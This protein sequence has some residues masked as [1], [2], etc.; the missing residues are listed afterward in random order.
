MEERQPY[1]HQ[2]FSRAEAVLGVLW[3][4]IASFISVFL[5]VFYLGTWIG[6]VPFPYTIVVALLFNC[7]LVKTSGLW[8]RFVPFQLAP[9]WVWCAGYAL[10]M[11]WSGVG[12]DQ[13][14]LNSFRSIALLIAGVAGGVW[15][16]REAK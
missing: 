11:V 5:E 8:T 12:G 13:L 16:L 4:C 15:A 6:P 9:L 7:V 1:V 14:L 3:L 10:F 2:G